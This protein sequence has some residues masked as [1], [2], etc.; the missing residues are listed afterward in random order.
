MTIQEFDAAHAQYLSSQDHGVLATLGPDGS[1]QAKP[2]GFR[3]DPQAA[4]IDIGGID[5]ERSAKFRNVA[6]HPQVAFTVDD[7]PDPDGGAAGVR[8]MEIRGTAEQLQV[9]DP[10]MRTSA[11][12]SFASTP[13]R[14]ISYNVAGSGAYSTDLDGS[15][16]SQDPVRPAIGLT[17]VAGERAR[18]AVERQVR[19]LQDGLSDVRRRGLQ[20]SLRRRRD[21]GQPV[22]GDRR[23]LRH[24][25]S[26]PRPH[27]RR[28]GSP[29]VTL[30]DRPGAHGHP[31]T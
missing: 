22:R 14:V 2:V 29:A 7:M 13:T 21:V 15:R 31:R 3:Y 27:A 16:A 24:A 8:F 28:R 1:P 11:R 9:D 4:T 23:R 17:D 18:E 25:A 30:R 26:D 12:G 19:E 20:P 5:L 6:T 10:P